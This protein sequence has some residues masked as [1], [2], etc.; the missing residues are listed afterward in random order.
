[1]SKS[2]TA[3]VTAHGAWQIVTLSGPLNENAGEILKPL[4]SKV[5][6]QCLLDFANVQSV[7]SCGIAEWVQFLDKLPAG[8]EVIYDRC[9]PHIV[10]TLN[11]MPSLL[12]KAKVRSVQRV[13]VCAS[14]HKKAAVIQFDVTKPMAVPSSGTVACDK[15]GAQ[16]HPDSPDEDYFEFAAAG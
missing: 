1:M 3:K 4:V 6:R 16:A 13:Y 8:S 12:E 11:L 5:G 15:C 2:I 10:S 9:P 7:N 14:G